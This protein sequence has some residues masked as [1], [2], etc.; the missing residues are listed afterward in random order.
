MFKGVTMLSDIQKKSVND[1]RK[2][3]PA[4]TDSIKS[5]FTVYEIMS[6]YQTVPGRDCSIEILREG[7]QKRV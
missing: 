7:H 4:L 5:D 3:H 1:F 6:H 2:L